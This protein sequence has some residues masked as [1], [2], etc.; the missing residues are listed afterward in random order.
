MKNRDSGALAARRCPAAV[1]VL[2]LAVV[3]SAGAFFVG[4]AIRDLSVGGVVGRAAAAIPDHQPGN[5]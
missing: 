2:F 5:R 4:S 3:F 1:L